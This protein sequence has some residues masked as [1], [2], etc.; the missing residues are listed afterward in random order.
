M[1]TSHAVTKIGPVRSF[2]ERQAHMIL[3]L[4]FIRLSLY[5]SSTYGF[6]VSIAFGVRRVPSSLQSKL[7]VVRV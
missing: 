1:L 7:L 4:L 6:G 2:Y 5:F 3:L